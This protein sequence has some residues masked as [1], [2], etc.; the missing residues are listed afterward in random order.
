MFKSYD[1][2]IQTDLN[3]NIVLFI[4]EEFDIKVIIKE[5]HL[6]DEFKRNT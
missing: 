5:K 4:K 2:T 6:K 3:K 1:I